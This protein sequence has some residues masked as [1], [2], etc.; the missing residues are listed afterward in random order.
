MPPHIL[1]RIPDWLHASAW[2]AV[3]TAAA[4][5]A[6]G[7]DDLLVAAPWIVLVCSPAA[8]SLLPL[9]QLVETRSRGWS[10]PVR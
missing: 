7:G 2:D 1:I 8:C 6:V 9:Q 4:V 3:S 5:A 10:R